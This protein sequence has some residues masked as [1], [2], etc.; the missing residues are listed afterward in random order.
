MRTVRTIAELRATLAPD[1]RAGLT[2]G[3]VPTM[4]ALHEG[5]L[6]LIERA[7]EQCDRV[8]VSLF[9][10][11]AQF[12]ERSDLDR[13]PRRLERDSTLAAQA[14]ADL[15]FAPSVEEV[16]PPGFA[17]SVEV[18]GITE[19]LEGAHRGAEHF[20]GVSTVV[21]KLLCIALPDV[22]YFGQKDA[23]QVLV[24]R[25]L[26]HDLNLPVQ[27]EVCPTVRESDGLAMSSR[28]ALLDERER[29][30][31]LALYAAL[32]AIED[33][34]AQGERRT[35]RLLEVGRQKLVAR[36]VHPEYLELV[37]PDTLESLE[38]LDRP[39]LLA[40]A[41]QVGATRLIDNLV[42]EP[43]SKHPTADPTSSS[44]HDLRST[45]GSQANLD[46]AAQ[47]SQVTPQKETA[48]CSA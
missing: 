20:R 5:H 38:W 41:A 12:N 17:T 33:Y 15:L 26:V 47:P 32:R 31:A 19:R 22:A 11:P 9:V 37:D 18:L 25:R 10:N 16:Y 46:P 14:G 3:L 21:T 24:I 42:L 30:Q 35:A 4:G 29:D 8:V 27:V 23:Q 43:A 48:T 34:A 1:R 40:I 7:R 2:I 13:Y 45:A 36:G 6:S 39:A 44:T 28:N